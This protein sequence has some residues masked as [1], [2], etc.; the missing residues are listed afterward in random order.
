ML[1]SRFR[2][3]AAGTGRSHPEE[4]KDKATAALFLDF[5]RKPEIVRLLAQ[6]GFTMP[7]GGSKAK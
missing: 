5:I 4:S 1:R 2:L 7:G 6:Y 3:R